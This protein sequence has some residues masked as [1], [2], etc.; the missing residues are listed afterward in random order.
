MIAKEI[1]TGSVP[2]YLQ[3]FSHH[4]YGILQQS[5]LNQFFVFISSSWLNTTFMENRKILNTGDLDGFDKVSFKNFLCSINF[6]AP[7]S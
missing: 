4:Y 7:L 6:V 3:T 2:S 1:S 5:I